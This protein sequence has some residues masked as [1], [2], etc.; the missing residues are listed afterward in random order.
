MQ[1]LLQIRNGIPCCKLELQ[2]RMRPRI[3]DLL[4][5]HIYKNLR[6]H[7]SVLMYDDVKGIQKNIFFVTHE[8]EEEAVADGKSKV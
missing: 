7:A 8:Q 6:D 1:D 4:R 3:A 5:P 2:H